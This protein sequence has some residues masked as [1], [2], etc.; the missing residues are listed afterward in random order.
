M[1]KNVPAVFF[2]HKLNGARASVKRPRVLELFENQLASVF[3]GVPNEL[4][5][6]GDSRGWADVEDPDDT[7][8]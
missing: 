2:Q 6:C 4:T 7:H 3:G 1:K 8:I 5:F